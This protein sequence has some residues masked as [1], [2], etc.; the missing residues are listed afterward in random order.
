MLGK[1]GH[2]PNNIVEGGGGISKR[3]L[4]ITSVSA[5][6][7]YARIPAGDPA[8]TFRPN[9]QPAEKAS[10][11]N[12]GQKIPDV[13]TS[14]IC[15]RFY[16]YICIRILQRIH[17]TRHISYPTLGTCSRQIDI[18]L[19]DGII[20]SV[21]FTGGCHGNTQGIAALVRGMKAADAIAR[22]E[23]IDCR[24]KGTSCPDQLAKALRQAL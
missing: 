6:F 9:P 3:L 15:N 13:Q 20:R 22:L 8:G 12:S 11:E 14:R 10:S 1:P 4:Q 18:E 16:R 23:G 17:M 2:S 21:T 7:F 19:E 24:G 5:M